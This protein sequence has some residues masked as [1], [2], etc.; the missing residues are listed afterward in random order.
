MANLVRQ[1]QHP[2]PHRHPRQDLVGESG[3]G[4]G[5]A[6][7]HTTGTKRASLAGERDDAIFAAVLASHTQEPVSENAAPE[8]GAQLLL[9]MDR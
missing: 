8:I 4:V 1:A 6:P 3:R 7:S 5:H 9:D 2:L